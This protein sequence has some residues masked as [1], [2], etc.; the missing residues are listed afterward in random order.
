[1]GIDTRYW[2][3]SGWQLF[4]Y[5]AAH[6]DHPQAL[7]NIMKD[8]LPCKFCRESTTQ[9]VKDHPLKG[10]PAK[11]LYEIHNMVNDKLRTQ[12]KNDPAVTDPGPDPTFEEVSHTYQSMKLTD[13]LGRDFLFSVAMNYPE[14]PTAEER[15][16]QEEFMKVLSDVY[17]VKGV[18]KNPTLESRKSYSKWMYAQLKSIARDLRASIPSYKGYVQRLKYYESGCEKKT[19]RGKTCRRAKGGRTKSRDHKRT[20]RIAHSNLLQGKTL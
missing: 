4:H 20:R 3:P 17:P 16:T 9:F 8:V 11:W 7:L 14:I 10:D 6:A 13:V 19:Y 2:G 1:M 5:I 18:F 15:A 12:C